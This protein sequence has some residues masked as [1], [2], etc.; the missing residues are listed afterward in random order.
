M[1]L[2]FI[3]LTGDPLKNYHRLGV[4]DRKLYQKITEKKENPSTGEK[5]NFFFYRGL[6]IPAFTVLK[7]HPSFAKSV[8]A[9]SEGLKVR[10]T[11]YASLLLGVEWAA[12]GKTWPFR[13]FRPHFYGV[14][15]FY[16]RKGS[17]CMAGSIPFLRGANLTEN[18]RLVLYKF[19]KSPKVFSCN[20]AACPWPS[21]FCMNE[22]GTMLSVFQG[23][24]DVFN[25][26]GTPIFEIIHKL[27]M[28]AM[29]F[30][31]ALSF[32]KKTNSIGSWKINMAFKSGKVL[33]VN[34]AGEDKSFK[35]Y[36][37]TK[38]NPL[39]LGSAPNG[40]SFGEKVS[41]KQFSDLELFHLMEKAFTKKTASPRIKMQ[42]EKFS[43]FT[44]CFNSQGSSLAK[45]RFHPRY[46]SG[47]YEQIKTIWKKPKAAYR[48]E[49]LKKAE[50]NYKKGINSFLL[51]QTFFADK[52]WHLAY[53]NIQMAIE[54]LR[55]Y[56]EEH[57]AR[58]YFLI[59]EFINNYSERSHFRLL[60]D[61]EKI[62]PQLPS[63]LKK[64]CLLFIW[65]LK[66][67]VKIENKKEQKN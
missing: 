37:L 5:I 9:Y 26:K 59:F 51:S 66:H 3:E 17:I 53:H 45:Q 44:S 22:Q 57:I 21:F 7:R 30:K 60:S 64:H 31:T 38:K 16:L 61:F 55:D 58:F 18:E 29:P 20:T 49:T 46:L 24:K 50:F 47:G 13:S 52:D 4:K 23:D 34:L 1:S 32:L 10:T 36:D 33:S 28:E 67:I 11:E 43:S 62:G 42:L 27:M 6:K 12:T 48:K 41:R 56:P 8:K 65:R 19:D 2:P 54:L 39:F 63:T 35:R 40:F 15:C 14:S 25:L